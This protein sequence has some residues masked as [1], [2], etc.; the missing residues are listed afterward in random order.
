MDPVVS[1]LRDLVAIDSVNPSLVAGAAGEGA[2]AEFI[3]AWLSRN[4]FDV[5]VDEVAPGRPNVIAVADGRGPGPTLLLC[6]HTDTVGVDGMTAPFSPSIRE[7]RLYGRGAQ[8][9]KA[10][11]AAM[12]AAA[13]SW[14]ASDR[15]GAGKVIVAAVADEEYASLGAGALAR[16]WRADEAVIPEPTDLEIGVAHKGFSCAEVTVHGRAAHGSRPAEGRDAILGMGRVLARLE[17]LDRSLQARTPHALLGAGSL[18]AGTIRGG[19]ELSVYPAECV[20]QVE[21]R[22][23]PDEAATVAMDEVTAIAADLAASDP[24]FVCDVRLLLARPA[25]AT[26]A[27]AAVVEHLDAAVRQRFGPRPRVGLS[28]WTDA[29]MLAATGTPAVLFGPRGGGLHSIEEHVLVEDVVGCRDVLRSWLA[30][31]RTH[32]GRA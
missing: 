10:G 21:R 32:Q 14:L 5:R 17:A 15:A 7:G 16:E 11:V 3:A 20:L 30:M 19:T 22:T 31:V 18:H 26:P 27:G 13:A 12:M 29:A 28:Y 6:G 24:D 23:L 2:I 8:D 9:M 25:Y 1:L 4:G